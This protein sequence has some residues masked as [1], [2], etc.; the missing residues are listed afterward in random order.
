MFL[1]RDW[2]EI[3]QSRECYRLAIP[4]S[5]HYY[6]FHII[7]KCFQKHALKNCFCNKYNNSYLS[8]NFNKF[9]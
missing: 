8:S 7:T 9:Y 2:Q 5:V 3:A 4:F 1:L 6:L